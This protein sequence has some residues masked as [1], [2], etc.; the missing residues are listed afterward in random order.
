MRKATVLLTAISVT[1]LTASPAAADVSPFVGHWEAVNEV[2]G[3]SDLGD[4]SRMILN[5]SAD[6]N[7]TVSVF[8]KDFGASACGTDANG[9]P[10]FAGQFKSQGIIDGNSLST[11]GRG[12]SGVGNGAIWCMASTPFELFTA[13]TE[14][15]PFVVT[16]DPVTDTLSDGFDLFHRVRK[17]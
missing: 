11:Y 17:N 2:P 13:P 9:E 16:Y 8:F 15:T 5:I 7:G 12:G 3:D 10:L 6:R 14:P 4:G 1:L